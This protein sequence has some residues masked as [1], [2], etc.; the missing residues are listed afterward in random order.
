MLT[1]LPSQDLEAHI[2]SLRAELWRQW[3][4]NHAEHCGKPWPHED[5]CYWP[6]PGVLEGVSQ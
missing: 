4:Y 6:P 5:E 2:A 3:E 1:E